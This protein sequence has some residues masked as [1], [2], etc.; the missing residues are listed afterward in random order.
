MNLLQLDRNIAGEPSFRTFVYADR[1]PLGRTKKQRL[2]H[3]PN[4]P[5]AL[6]HKR[7][8]KYVLSRGVSMPSATGCIAGWSSKLN[9]QAH[10]GNQH[11]YQIDMRDAYQ[12]VDLEYLATIFEQLDPQLRGQHEEV[13]AFV[14]TYCSCALGGLAT[15]ANASPLLFN[16]YCEVRLDR[17][18]REY[19]ELRAISYTRYLDDLTF[20]SRDRAIGKQ[21]RRDL[22]SFVEAAGFQVNHSKSRVV[23]IERQGTARITGI[24]LNSHGH[25]M[26]PAR[27]CREF[28]RQLRAALE[29]KALNRQQLEGM[30]GLFYSATDLDHPTKKERELVQ[31]I[32]RYRHTCAT[33]RRRR[34]TSL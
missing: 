23:D 18:V 6:L 3:A 2:L 29:G 15:G 13:A 10:A 4:K 9:A 34:R 12:A 26:L 16:L 31:L 20:S 32:H 27:W 21:R 22:R 28:N 1:N 33:K 24:L 8:I 17:F 25:A 5:M 14:K 7:L 11:L 30:I 19:C